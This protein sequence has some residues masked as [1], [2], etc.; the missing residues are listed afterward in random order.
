MSDDKDFE[1]VLE[2]ED[3]GEEST[4][5]TIILSGTI[6]EEDLTCEYCKKILSSAQAFTYH[7]KSKHDTKVIKEKKP[8]KG[9]IK[10]AEREARR[11]LNDK[12]KKIPK[13]IMDLKKIVPDGASKN[14]RARLLFQAIKD[15]KTIPLSEQVIQDLEKR[16]HEILVKNSEGLEKQSPGQDSPRVLESPSK[17]IKIS[18]VGE[19]KLKIIERESLLLNESNPFLSQIRS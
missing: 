11:E 6:T 17:K 1:E 10:K 13:S 3:A 8:R 9:D 7:M 19:E 4:E 5:E 18:M 15:S 12:Q 14:E 2:E 16:E